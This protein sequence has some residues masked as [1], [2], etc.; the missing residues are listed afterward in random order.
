MFIDV[1]FFFVGRCHTDSIINIHNTTK[2]KINVLQLCYFMCRPPKIFLND[3]KDLCLCMHF[4]FGFHTFD[5]HTHNRIFFAHSNSINM[6]TRTYTH[7]KYGHEI[8]ILI[9]YYERE[10]LNFQSAIYGKNKY[11]CYIGTHM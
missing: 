3:A 2:L 8:D 1:R 6:I 4:G 10:L 5:I 9:Q 7:K 11:Y